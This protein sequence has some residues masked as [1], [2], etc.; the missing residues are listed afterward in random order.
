VPCAP[1]GC[2]TTAEAHDHNQFLT[3]ICHAMGVTGIEQVGDLG[4]PGIL[5][6]V[7]A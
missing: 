1:A 2:S 5:P 7:L 3:T 6:N 4:T